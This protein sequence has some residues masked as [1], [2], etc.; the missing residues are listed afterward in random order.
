MLG[1]HIEGST[2]TDQVGMPEHHIE[3]STWTDQV[4][5]PRAPHRRKHMHDTIW[6][7]ADRGNHITLAVYVASMQVYKGVHYFENSK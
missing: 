3:G 4:G 2:W 6:L 5:M 1:H 7:G